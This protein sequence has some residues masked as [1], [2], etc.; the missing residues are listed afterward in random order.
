MNP[1]RVAYLCEFPTLL[2]GERSLLEF[3]RHRRIAGVDPIVVAP[4]RGRLADALAAA[5]VSHLHLPPRGLRDL[6]AIAEECIHRQVQIVHGNSLMT[7]DAALLL[8]NRLA[9]PAVTHV[10]DMM[11]LSDAKAERLRRLDAVVAVS[12]AVVHW[13][14]QFSVPATCIYNAIDPAEIRRL[15]NPPTLRKELNIGPGDLLVGCIGQWAL[16]KGQDLFVRAAERVLQR[17]RACHFVLIGERYSDKEESVAFEIGLRQA[18]RQGPLQDRLHL[19]G[20]R[21]DVPSLLADMSVLVVPSRQEPLSRTLLEGLALGVPC[22]ATEV[23][24][25]AELLKG[26]EYGELVRADDAERLADGII[27]L[28]AHE[29]RREELR[30]RTPAWVDRQFS[31]QKQA[32]ALRELY[33][34]LGIERDGGIDSDREG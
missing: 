9:I 29:T 18:A 12:N 11:R 23:G 8:G 3:L 1:R 21:D 4:A 25:N 22:V 34:S 13:L 2:G 20:Y 7:A 6:D 33:D 28:L 16:R 32:N 27:Q 26:G 19:L 24:G 30:A 31:P 17:M 10:R 15:A 14:A 5:G